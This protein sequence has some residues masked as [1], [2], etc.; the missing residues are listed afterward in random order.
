SLQTFRR[1]SSPPLLVRASRRSLNQSVK[2]IVQRRFEGGSEK[3]R[4]VRSPKCE[5][6]LTELA[7]YSVYQCGGCGAVLC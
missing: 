7:D 6:L 4:L 2:E 3:V 1:S 5:N